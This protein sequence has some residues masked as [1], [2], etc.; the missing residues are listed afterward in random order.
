MDSHNVAILLLQMQSSLAQISLS[1]AYV[2]SSHSND[3]K[4]L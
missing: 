1:V 3:D 2:Q 4:R